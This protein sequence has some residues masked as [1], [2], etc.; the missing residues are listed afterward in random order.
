MGVNHYIQK[1]QL[2]QDFQ[3]TLKAF[4]AIGFSEDEKNEIFKIVALLIHLGNINFKQ[5]NGDGFS[6]VDAEDEGS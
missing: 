3:E 6:E 4:D 5:S 1:D 2:R